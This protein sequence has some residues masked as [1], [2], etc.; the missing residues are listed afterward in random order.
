MA[1]LLH[2][3][4]PSGIRALHRYLRGRNRPAV[5]LVCMVGA[6]EAALRE[7]A[8]SHRALPGRRDLNRCFGSPFAGAEGILAEK[9]LEL[10]HDAQPECLV[11]IHNTSGSSPSFAVTVV[12]DLQHQTLA[13]L[14]TNRLVVSD[15]R[16]GTLMELGETEFPA[17]TIECGGALDPGSSEVA[18]QGL[19]RFAAA[20]APCASDNGAVPLEILENPLR[21]ELREGRQLA[22]SFKA[23]P[24]VDL[25]LRQDIESFNLR[26]LPAGEPLGWVATGGLEA[27]EVN[28]PGGPKRPGDYFL[29]SDGNLRTAVP[30]RLSM[31][32]TVSSI[33]ISDCLFYLFD[34]MEKRD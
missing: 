1:T 10:L 16:M 14:F 31:A 29:V 6:V 23:V 18:M 30:L 24:G 21:V 26:P 20:A 4:E 3:N 9:F 34:S 13:S 32:T 11:D 25:T 7:P 17:V 33:A 2:G 28:G 22:F 19:E 15:L 8:F 12:R 27:L 5:D